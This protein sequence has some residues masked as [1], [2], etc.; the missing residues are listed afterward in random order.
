MGWTADDDPIVDVE[1]N[2]APST[3]R[4]DSPNVKELIIACKINIMP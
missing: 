1:L 2:S 3:Q 4:S